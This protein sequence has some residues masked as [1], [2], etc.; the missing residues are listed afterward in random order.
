M[1]KLLLALPLLFTVSCGKKTKT[2]TVE[3][4]K[5]LQPTLLSCKVYSV[6]GQ[7]KLPN[8]SALESLGTIV[9]DRLDEPS[10]PET[11]NFSFLAG[12]SLEAQTQ[13]EFGLVCEGEYEIPVDGEYTFFIN[14]DDGSKLFLN[15]VP[16]V[17]NDGLHGMVKRSFKSNF[18]EGLLKVRVEYFNNTG[19]KG[20]VL[21]L[22]RTGSS[23]EEPVVFFK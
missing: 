7:N 9:T 12:T 17:I 6:V 10:M 16:V 4:V 21:S 15:D 20:L 5:E 11:S 1:K 3:V 23:F 2:K 8:F 19:P 18:T 22:R 13:K 14:S